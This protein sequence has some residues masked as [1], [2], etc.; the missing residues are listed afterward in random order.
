MDW[1]WTGKRVKWLHG[2]KLDPFRWYLP[3]R[4][5]LPFPDDLDE[6][7]ILSNFLRK[8]CNVGLTVFL[9]SD[10]KNINS[11]YWDSRHEWRKGRSRLRGILCCQVRFK[12]GPIFLWN[13]TRKLSLFHKTAKKNSEDPET[14]LFTAWLSVAEQLSKC[15]SI[16]STARRPY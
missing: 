7:L 4:T 1:K 9:K 10:S 2:T 13:A 8:S 6:Y 12:K 14:Q 5:K 3:G 11:Q 15:D 16:V